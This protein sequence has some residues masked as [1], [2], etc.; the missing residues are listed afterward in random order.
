MTL[1]QRA[2]IRTLLYFDIFGHPLNRGELFAF[3]R[4]SPSENEFQD[5]IVILMEKGL[6]GHESGYYFLKDGSSSIQ[7]RIKKLNRS[8]RYL[9]IARF[10]AE[11][12]YWHPYVRSV[13]VSGSLSKNSHSQKDDIDFF[14]I[15]SANSALLFPVV[16]FPEVISFDIPTG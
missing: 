4:V 7:E 9:K 6:I 16:N 13:L 3:L 2:I 5:A 8:H 11:L 10:I 14:I 15:A 12:I 1:T